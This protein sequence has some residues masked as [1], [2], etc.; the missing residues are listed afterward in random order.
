MI[1]A[2]SGYLVLAV[3]SKLY[4]YCMHKQGMGQGDTDLLCYIGAFL[5]FGGW[6]ISLLIGSCIGSVIGI[7]YIALS[8]K[9]KQAK[10]PFGPFLVIGAL[11]YTLWGTWLFELLFPGI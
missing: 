10:I 1:G 4:A 9:D 6:W 3:I 2:L 5:G 11:A 8:G 7:A